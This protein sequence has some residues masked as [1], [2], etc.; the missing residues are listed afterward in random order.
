[1][2]L[3]RFEGENL[4]PST[5]GWRLCEFNNRDC[6]KKFLVLASQGVDINVGLPSDFPRSGPED[7]MRW[8]FASKPA[9]PPNIV[10]FV[11]ALLGLL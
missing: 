1:M 6:I 7:A 2:P 5:P 11:A 4:H 8:A 10:L 3:R 9:S